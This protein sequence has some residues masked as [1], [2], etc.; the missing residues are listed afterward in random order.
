MDVSIVSFNILGTPY[1]VYKT[2]T[3]HLLPRYRRYRFE[4]IAQELNESDTDIICLQEVHTYLQLR[5]LKN[6]LS[7]FPYVCYKRF[8]YGPKGGLVIFSRIPIAGHE[9]IM[10]KRRGSFLNKSI[11]DKLSRK[12]MLLCKLADYP[13]YL[14]NTHITANIDWDWTPENRYIPLITAQLKQLKSFVATLSHLPIQLIIT[15]DFNMPAK[16][17]Y[18]QQF[19]DQHI[20]IDIFHASNKPTYNPEHLPQGKSSHRIDYIFL[21]KSPFFS[22]VLETEYLFTKKFCLTKSVE[23]FLSDHVGLRAKLRFSFPNVDE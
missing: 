19:L 18:Y 16:S 10:Y 7:K 13:I 21:H 20:L 22:K 11:V 23:S 15:G 12:G 14:L 2:P 8:L 4:K 5:I 3:S 17:I 6:N 9:Y 1:A